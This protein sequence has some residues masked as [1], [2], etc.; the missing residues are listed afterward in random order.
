[1]NMTGAPA[2]KLPK[3]ERLS[4]KTAVGAL[5]SCGR[6]GATT[7]LGYCW[8]P[9]TDGGTCRMMVSVPKKN[10]KRAVKRNLLKRR[11]REG[12]RLQKNLLGKPCDILFVYKDKSVVESKEIHSEIRD[13]L[14]QI[15]NSAK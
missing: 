7:H 14:L 10:F 6:R 8:K 13:I 5:L 11:M 3:E 12:Y 1:M 2:N 4:G 15:D 9:R